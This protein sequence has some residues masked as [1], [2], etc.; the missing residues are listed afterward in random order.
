MH[1]SS[2]YSCTLYFLV[3]IL[4]VKFKKCYTS[5]CLR[6]NYCTKKHKPKMWRLKRWWNLSKLKTHT[7]VN[8]GIFFNFIILSPPFSSGSLQKTLSD[9]NGQFPSAWGIMIKTWGR[10]SIE[11]MSKNEKI[12]F[13]AHKCICSNLN[14]INLKL[15]S[16]H[17]GIYR[18][19]KKFKKDSG[20]IDLLGVHRNMRGCILEINCELV[21]W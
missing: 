1:I 13:L 9:R 3:K 16:N 14:T 10:V 6:L 5:T 11:G 18:F 4:L 17:G 12:Q 2:N 20:G 19:M 8:F 15:Y 21:G 7:S